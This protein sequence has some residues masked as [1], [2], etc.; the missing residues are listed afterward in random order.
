M[1]LASDLLPEKSACRRR[2]V[3]AVV[4]IVQRWNGRKETIVSGG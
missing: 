4:V 3:A 2:R 1:E